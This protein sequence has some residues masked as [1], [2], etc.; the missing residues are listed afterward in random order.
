MKKIESLTP[1]QEKAML[2][3]RDEWLAHGRSTEP[4]NRPLA[5]KSIRTSLHGK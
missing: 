1:R 5:E 4:A 2:A 3:Y